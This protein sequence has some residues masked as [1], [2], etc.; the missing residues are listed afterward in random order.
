MGAAAGSMHKQAPSGRLIPA[1]GSPA[2]TLI[3]QIVLCARLLPQIEASYHLLVVHTTHLPGPKYFKLLKEKFCFI[4][5][6]FSD[7]PRP[8]FEKNAYQQMCSVTFP[9]MRGVLFVYSLLWNITH[10]LLC[11]S[12]PLRIKL[13][14][15]YNFD[16]KPSHYI[17]WNVKMKKTSSYFT[18]PDFF[19]CSLIEMNEIEWVNENLLQFLAFVK[20]GG[21]AFLSKICTL[22]KFFKTWNNFHSCIPKTSYYNSVQL[23]E[24]NSW[25]YSILKITLCTLSWGRI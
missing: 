8:F 9:T 22:L 20:I 12:G 16:I 7:N 1:G 17:A 6:I 15:G 13:K 21:F 10:L 19:D 5:Q 18:L 4:H 25:L 11:L 3:L 23:L 24:L 2:V 14:G